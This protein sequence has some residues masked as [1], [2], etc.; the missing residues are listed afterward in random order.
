MARSHLMPGR[1]LRRAG[2]IRW[3]RL[4]GCLRLTHVDLAGLPWHR[5]SHVRQRDVLVA[6]SHSTRATISV[7]LRVAGQPAVLLAAGRAAT[8]PS[9]AW[10]KALA[11]EG[12]ADG[13]PN[14]R[15]PRTWG[16]PQLLL[17]F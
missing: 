7:G 12:G 2:Q 14:R 11:I 3:R 17:G 4:A 6:W 13:F 9:C 1:P 5:S 10:L 16:L 15:T 8:R